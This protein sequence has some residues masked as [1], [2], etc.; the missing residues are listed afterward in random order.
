MDQDN[1]EQ[2]YSYDEA[3]F[4]LKKAAK[5]AAKKNNTQLLEILHIMEYFH[6]KVAEDIDGEE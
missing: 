5:E 4:I 6:D 2:E 3:M 1:I